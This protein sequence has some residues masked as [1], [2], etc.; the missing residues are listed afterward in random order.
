MDHLLPQIDKLRRA[1]APYHRKEREREDCQNE[2]D[3]G[4]R[5]RLI[6]PFSPPGER[7]VEVRHKSLQNPHQRKKRQ[8]HRRRQQEADPG[9]VVA[10]GG[11]DRTAHAKD[12]RAPPHHA[13][14]LVWN[15]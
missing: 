11:Q 15:A 2:A 7:T 3:Q 1:H 14:N 5:Q 10:D 9:G 4:W 6:Q 13:N 12:H 8:A